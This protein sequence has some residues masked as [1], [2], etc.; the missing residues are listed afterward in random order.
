[1]LNDQIIINERE[2]EIDIDIYS[3]GIDGIF[4]STNIY[5]PLRRNDY[6]NCYCQAVFIID[7]KDES[8]PKMIKT[9]TR[10]V[11]IDASAIVGAHLIDGKMLTT[12]NSVGFGTVQTFHEWLNAILKSYD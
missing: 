4:T 1:M 7:N 2:Y 3:S 9:Q 12:A 10:S 11:K 6:E 5:E 8:N